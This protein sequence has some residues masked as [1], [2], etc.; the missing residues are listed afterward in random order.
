MAA[1]QGRALRTTV[2]AARHTTMVAM[3]AGA[4]FHSFRQGKFIGLDADSFARLP[5]ITEVDF[6]K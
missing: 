6:I 3:V 2:V 1:P 4:G 5:R